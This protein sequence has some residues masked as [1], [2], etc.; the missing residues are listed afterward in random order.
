MPTISIHL[1]VPDQS[2]EKDFIKAAICEARGQARQ[3]WRQ[4]NK[5]VQNKGGRRKL[6]G[7]VRKACND[8]WKEWGEKFPRRNSTAAVLVQAVTLRVPG[9]GRGKE[10]REDLRTIE[11]YVREWISCNLT[12][13]QVPDSWLRKPAG[14]KLVRQQAWISAVGLLLRNDLDPSLV[15]ELN[16]ALV[17][18]T[19][20]Q[21]VDRLIEQ[22]NK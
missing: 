22:R 18:S 15:K 13:A 9:K 8:I 17:S 16:Q 19:N 11:K 3:S 2:S 10:K 21:M 6:Q 14:Q 7:A 4:R 20:K 5:H 1:E 12:I